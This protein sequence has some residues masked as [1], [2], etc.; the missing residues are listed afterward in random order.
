MSEDGDDSRKNSIA[1]RRI[2]TLA[3]VARAL[4]IQFPGALYHVT[5]R[6]NAGQAIYCDDEDRDGFLGILARAV[7]RFAWLCHAFCLMGNHYHVLIETPRPNLAQGMRDLNGTYAQHFNERHGRIGH[8][9][10][11]RYRA[12]LVQKE[13]HLLE[14]SR[15]IVRNPVR[16]ALCAHPADWPWTSYLGTAGLGRSPIFLTTDWLLGQFSDERIEAQTRYRA[17]VDELEAPAVPAPRSGLYL[18]SGEFIERHSPKVP[19]QDVPRSQWEPIRPPLAAL[20]EQAGDDGMLAAF[21][22]H[23]YQLRE[24]AHHLGIHPSTAGRRLRRLEL[25]R[26][27]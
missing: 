6:G 2:H 16:A 21:Y 5:A 24:I 12:I 17:F 1:A 15:Y 19:V 9:F 25:D 23:G 3:L 11:G 14:L 20:F 10:Q 4:R 7:S 22:S 8:L 26:K 27:T 13:R 18:G